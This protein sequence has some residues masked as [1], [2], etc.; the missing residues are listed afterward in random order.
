MAKALDSQVGGN[1][2]KS[3]RIQPLEY[4]IANNIPFVEGCVIKY[5]SRWKSKGGVADLQKARHMLDVLIESQ[6]G[7]NQGES[8]ELRM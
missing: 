2:Y 1:H 5:V 7:Q 6:A 4:C 3:M 8:D